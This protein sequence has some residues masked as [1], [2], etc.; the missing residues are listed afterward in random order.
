MTGAPTTTADITPKELTIA[1][2]FTADNK[3]YDGNTTAEIASNSLTLAGLITG[4]TVEISTATA[5]A[6]FSDRKVGAAKTV[7]LS[8]ATLIGANAANYT[9]SLASAPTTMADIMPKPLTLAGGFTVDNKLFDGNNSTVRLVDT[10]YLVGVISPD[11]VQLDS[12]T[13]VFTSVNPGEQILVVITNPLRLLGQDT[14]NYIVDL[15]NA[16][17]TRANIYT[18]NPSVLTSRLWALDDSLM[19]ADSTTI[20]LELRNQQGGLHTGGNEV[21]L[22]TT[23]LG[24]VSSATYAGSGQYHAKLRSQVAGL[25]VVSAQLN[26]AMVVDTAGVVFIP[27]GVD[28][29]RA[30]TEIIVNNAVR[31]AD[32]TTYATVIVMLRDQ[33]GNRIRRPNI[34]IRFNATLGE[35]FPYTSS[36][37]RVAP[38]S[39]NG[40]VVPTDSSGRAFVNIR[41]NIAGSSLITAVVDHDVNA[42]TTMVPVVNGSPA[43]VTFL[44]GPVVKLVITREPSDTVRS[45]EVFDIQPQVSLSDQFGNIVPQ[46]G[47]PITASILNANIQLGTTIQLITNNAGRV[48][49]SDLWMAGPTGEYQIKFEAP[50]LNADTTIEIHMVCPPTVTNVTREICENSSFTIGQRV[51]SASGNYQVQLQNQWGCDSIVNLDLIVRPNDTTLLTQAI[52]TGGSMAI[53]N[54]V[55]NAPGTYYVPFVNHLG[56]DSIVQANIYFDTVIHVN[57]FR[58]ICVGDSFLV[59]NNSFQWTGIYD[60]TLVASG[61]CDSIVRLNLSVNPISEV[62][63]YRTICQGDTLQFNGQGFYT[64]GR[65]SFNFISSVGCDSIAILDLTVNPLPSVQLSV[66]GNRQLC[67]GDSVVLEVAT[68]AGQTYQ[69]LRNG[70]AI[71]G[72]INP[73]FVALNG[74]HYAVIV[75]SSNGCRDTSVVTS[76]DGNNTINRTLFAL[77]GDVICAGSTTTLQLAGQKGNLNLQWYLD[78]LPVV[79]AADSFLVVNQPGLYYVELTNQAGCS[80][81]T[82]GLHVRINPANPAQIVQQS[83]AVNNVVQGDDIQFIIQ[84]TGM[85]SFAWQKFINGTWTNLN[86]DGIHF[87]VTRSTLRITNTPL[88]YDSS[89]YRVIAGGACGLPDTS[90]FMLLR[91]ETSNRVTTSASDYGNMRILITPCPG[92]T[93]LVPVSVTAA[94]AVSSFLVKLNYDTSALSYVDYIT[95]AQEVSSAVVTNNVSGRIDVNYIS[96]NTTNIQDGELI[97]LRFVAYESADLIWDSTGYYTD[98]LG[99]GIPTRWLNGSVKVKP[100]LTTNLTY[101]MCRGESYLMGGV[102]YTEGGVYSSVLQGFNSCDSTVNLT[103][104]VNEPDTVRLNRRICSGGFVLVG[105]QPV[106]TEGSYVFSLKNEFGCDSVVM[107]N[108]QVRSSDLDTVDVTVCP[109]GYYVVGAQTFNQEGTYTVVMSNRFGCDSTVVLN[110]FVR[111]QVITNLSVSLCA[112]STYSVGNRT[113]NQSG[114]YNVMLNT[115]FGCDSL[116]NL[117][118]N[119]PPTDTTTLN[120][121]ICQGD[122]ISVGGQNFTTT[123]HYYVN[124]QNS[125]SCDSIVELVLTVNAPDTLALVGSVCSGDVYQIGSQSFTSTGVYAVNLINQFGCDSLV[126]LTLTVNETDSSDLQANLCSGESIVIGSQ[127]FSATGVYRVVMQNASGCDSIINLQL[128]VDDVIRVRIDTTICFGTT[129]ELPDG[130]FVTQSGVYIDTLLALGGC[131]SIITTTLTVRMKPDFGLAKYEQRCYGDYVSLNVPSGTVVSWVGPNDFTAVGPNFS[132]PALGNGGVSAFIFTALLP[133]GCTYSDTLTIDSRACELIIPQGISPNGDGM[134]DKFHIIGLDRYP[135]SGVKIYNRAGSLVY[136]ATPYQNDF[137]GL[138]NRNMQGDL[139]QGTYFYMLDLKDGNPPITGYIYLSR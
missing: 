114:I 138:A 66:N 24:V 15:S 50:G 32:G 123:G 93:V 44:P 121:A 55:I 41:S 75:T 111:Q 1:G 112:G 57:L 79:G 132:V 9:I 94:N 45:S 102:V 8:N 105:G 25:A 56:C 133:D 91:V 63:V 78:S 80:G 65:Y 5:S 128:F 47:V 26:G 89:Y 122:I 97:A 4:D 96:P 110:L 54:T 46:A 73:R 20:I 137:S 109:N 28:T 19:V 16:P 88:Q 131:D 77:H 48:N 83:P 100:I 85:T 103:L 52:C 130:S 98:S 86:N 95:I 108:L 127:A 113:F 129:Y 31:P 116:V 10:V 106:N 51:F 30:G 74:G 61:G 42:G 72:A 124:L 134:N 90:N 99:F 64:A 40:F 14:A 7:A 118:L 117:V 18:P 33:F 22:F 38:A 136:E 11:D 12:F 70:T 92:D 35:M 104:T 36:S 82:P 125:L 27:A 101:S 23:N 6:S 2:S 84:G 139:T 37:A 120:E 115:R 13:T 119:I 71:L 81:V 68:A 76:I 58:A 3:V 21:V 87:G 69:W 43:A 62:V 67:I 126:N 29:S 107:L 53:G 17:T 60:V 39:S 59:G 34:D 135:E 49:Y